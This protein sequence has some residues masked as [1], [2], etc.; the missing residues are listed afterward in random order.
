M[1]EDKMKVLIFADL[2]SHNYKD[3]SITEDGV[4]S[5][6]ADCVGTVAQILISARE[7]NADEIWFLGDLFKLKNNL[8]SQV[9]QLTMYELQNLADN[10]PLLLVPGHHDYRMWTH[11]PIMMEM[12]ADFSGKTKFQIKL[13]DAAGWITSKNANV[14]IYVEPCIRGVKAIN[15]RLEKLKPRENAVFLSHADV[16][17][18]NYRGFVV[19][20]GIDADLLSERFKW[21]FIGHWHTPKKLRRNVISVGA[22]LQHTFNDVGGKRGWWIF[23]TDSNKLKHIENLEAPRFWDIEIEEEDELQ[24][25]LHEGAENAELEP[26]L[27]TPGN[28]HKDFFRIKVLGQTLPKGLS[29]IRWKRITYETPQTASKIRSELKFS[30]SSDAL[31]KKYVEARGGKLNHK[32]LI[33]IG[34][35]YLQ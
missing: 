28:P 18:V 25:A 6:L 15:E 3:F 7:N 29:H 30:D 22:A 27:R 33:E 17:G 10:Y 23:D 16:K 4:N 26:V 2:H 35:R 19:D 13:C 12:L 20:N 5:R 14:Q 34:L 21:S 1:E 8:D 31:I 24:K 11:D 9:I 32:K